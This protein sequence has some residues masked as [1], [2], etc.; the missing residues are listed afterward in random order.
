MLGFVSPLCPLAS[1]HW[2]PQ[3]SVAAWATGTAARL[4]TSIT[5]HALL[6]GDPLELLCPDPLDGPQAHGGCAG[7]WGWGSWAPWPAHTP[8]SITCCVDT[9]VGALPG[10]PAFHKPGSCVDQW[11][12]L[13]GI[14]QEHQPSKPGCSRHTL[15]PGATGRCSFV[16]RRLWH[17]VDFGHYAQY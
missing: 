8:L 6:G 3:P 10:R 2:L 9:E 12:H 17:C 14:I 1:R 11:R 5:A 16:N 7:V 13:V 4:G 15:N